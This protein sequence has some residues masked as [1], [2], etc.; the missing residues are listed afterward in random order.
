MSNYNLIWC[1]QFGVVFLFDPHN[2]LE[3]RNRNGKSTMLH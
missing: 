1:T 3:S 2:G